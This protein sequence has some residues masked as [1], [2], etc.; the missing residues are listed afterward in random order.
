M[1]KTVDVLMEVSKNEIVDS[2][3]NICKKNDLPL[4]L[5]NIIL[6]VLQ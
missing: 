1:I 5:L 4:Y 2:I 6:S 3:N